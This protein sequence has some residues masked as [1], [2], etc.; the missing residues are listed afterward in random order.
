MSIIYAPSFRLPHQ[1]PPP[2]VKVNENNSLCKELNAAFLFNE[3]GGAEYLDSTRFDYHATRVGDADW[4]SSER[5][6]VA[7]FDGATDYA[8]AGTGCGYLLSNTYTMSVAVWFKTDETNPGNDGVVYFGTFSDKI[9]EYTIMLLG[10]EIRWIMHDG[11]FDE[12]LA[13]SDLASW[14]HL[15]TTYDGVRAKL[16]LDGIEEIDVAYAVQLNFAAKL[17]ILGGYYNT[18]Y[19][20][21]GMISSVQI[22]GRSLSIHEV[23]QLYKDSYSMYQQDDLVVGLPS[24]SEGVGEQVMLIT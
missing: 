14:H 22:W 12:S 17:L 8:N 6:R 15:V 7:T 23:Q 2:G 20:L 16:Y 21:D 13:F 18:P 10:D 4:A 19:T 11:P 9:G 5:G 1:K 24:A 3:Y